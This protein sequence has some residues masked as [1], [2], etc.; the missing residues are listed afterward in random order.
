V[1]KMVIPTEI[2]YKTKIRNSDYNNL[3]LFCKKFNV[4]KAVMLVNTSEIQTIDYK[5]LT[6][7]M[8]PLFNAV[9]GD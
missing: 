2:K 3:Y 8:K 9:T 7:E 4:Q 1:N 6:I 5:G